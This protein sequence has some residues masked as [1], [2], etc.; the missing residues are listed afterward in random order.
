MG[1]CDSNYEF[2]KKTPEKKEDIKEINKSDENKFNK[3]IENKIRT[4]QNEKH[5][6][7]INE[8]NEKDN[9]KNIY[10]KNELKIVLYP[11]NKPRYN[12]EKI[13]LKSLLISKTF[14]YSFDKNKELGFINSNVPLLNGFYKAYINHYP[15]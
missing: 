5:K 6:N 12:F 11:E 14:A 8:T 3:N 7:K 9:I 10:D 1:V 15:I 13:S 4:E 2:N